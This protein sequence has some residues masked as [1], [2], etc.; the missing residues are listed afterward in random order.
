LEA[1]AIT[2]RYCFNY[3]ETIALLLVEPVVTFRLTA[4]PGFQSLPERRQAEKSLPAVK[5]FVRD[6]AQSGIGTTNGQVMIDNPD[7]HGRRLSNG[8][9]PERIDR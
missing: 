3:P 5:R 9:C 6:P 2:N 4:R 8:D 1:A 7:D